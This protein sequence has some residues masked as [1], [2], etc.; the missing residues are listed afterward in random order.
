[1]D[2]SEAAGSVSLHS[3]FLINVKAE[4]LMGACEEDPCPCPPPHT[5]LRAPL[6]D[7]GEDDCSRQGST[8]SQAG[9]LLSLDEDGHGGFNLTHCDLNRKE[10]NY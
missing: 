4:L 3:A 8:V 10:H 9:F 7:S 6:T 2:V 1:M 5:L